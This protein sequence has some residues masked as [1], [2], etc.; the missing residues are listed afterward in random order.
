MRQHVHVTKGH[1]HQCIGRSPVRQQRPVG[2]RNIATAQ[3]FV[4]QEVH[5]LWVLGLIETLDT[6]LVAAV[7]CLMQEPSGGIVMSGSPDR[8]FVH[9]KV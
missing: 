7:E 2:P 4:P 8:Y 3:R 1:F 9:T 5:L 6:R